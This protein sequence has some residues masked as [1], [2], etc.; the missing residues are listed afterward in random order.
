MTSPISQGGPTACPQC[1]S[2]LIRYRE[3]RS[4]WFCDACDH[5]WVVAAA[6]TAA[7]TPAARVF[8]S[9][10]R[11]DGL[12]FARRLAGDLESRGRHSVWL[13]LE[14]IE[15]GGLWEVRIEQ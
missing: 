4:D 7:E 10:A 14:D 11:A 12:D 3:H 8:V 1:G 13:D 9:Y 5:R 2:P 15:K 6:P